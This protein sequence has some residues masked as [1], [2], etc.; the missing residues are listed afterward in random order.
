MLIRFEKESM[1]RLYLLDQTFIPA[2]HIFD[3]PHHE[4]DRI[5]VHA[6]QIDI[7]FRI[8]IIGID[9]NIAQIAEP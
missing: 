4:F 8:F 3:Q 1:R 6:G 7:Q 5:A 9:N 2:R